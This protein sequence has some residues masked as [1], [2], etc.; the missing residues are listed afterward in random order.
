MIDAWVTVGVAVEKV[1]WFIL[2]HVLR[3]DE[4]DQV[5]WPNWLGRLFD[6]WDDRWHRVYQWLEAR[7]LPGV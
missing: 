5:F 7:S 3:P 1:E 4:N 2:F 6:W